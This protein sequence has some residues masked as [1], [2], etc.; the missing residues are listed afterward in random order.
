M[1]PRF[2]LALIAASLIAGCGDMKP[3]IWP[4]GESGPRERAR[5]PANAREYT[6]ASN[7]SFHVR[8]LDGGAVW[9]I[10]P[11]REVRLE[12]LGDNRYGKG[13]LVLELGQDGA[14]LVDGATTT[15][16]GCKPA[17]G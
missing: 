13:T 16:S 15:Y 4:F 9:L 8:S 2:S 11:E 10:L 7:K 5:E 12:R 1:N 14:S 3:K 6:C 17:A